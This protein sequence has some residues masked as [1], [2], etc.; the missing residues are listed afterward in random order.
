MVHILHVE[1]SNRAASRA[2]LGSYRLGTHEQNPIP[3]L[4]SNPHGFSAL[5]DADP[6]HEVAPATVRTTCILTVTAHGYSNARQ[7]A[8]FRTGVRVRRT[9]AL[10]KGI[11]YEATGGRL[12]RTLRFGSTLPWGGRIDHHQR[13]GDGRTGLGHLRPMERLP[14]TNLRDAHPTA[15][16]EVPHAAVT[17]SRQATIL[18]RL[19]SFPASA[20]CTLRRSPRRGDR[21]ER[22][23]D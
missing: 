12:L 18:R 19:L 22:R 5:A 21:F 23:S 10:D 15:R 14:D 11:P 9:R 1:P 13:R 17:A 2:D 3:K 8:R 7:H 4:Q 6:Y 16:Q 20:R